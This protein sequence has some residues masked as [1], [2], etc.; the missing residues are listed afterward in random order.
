[1]DM[2]HHIDIDRACMGYG[3]LKENIFVY[4]LHMKNNTSTLASTAKSQSV[5][6]GP[7]WDDKQS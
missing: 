2:L 3:Y 1:M 7:T 4:I 5:F 6:P